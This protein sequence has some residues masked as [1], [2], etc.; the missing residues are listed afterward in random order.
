MKFGGSPCNTRLRET[1]RLVSIRV[2]LRMHE[3]ILRLS[4][5]GRRVAPSGRRSAASLPPKNFVVRPF[6]SQF[7]ATFFI[8]YLVLP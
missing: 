7:I 8:F 4:W 2:F 3:K 5:E 6:S 1:A